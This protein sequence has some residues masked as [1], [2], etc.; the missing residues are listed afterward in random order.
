MAIELVVMEKEGMQDTIEI[1]G[2]VAH[3][4]RNVPQDKRG[5]VTLHGENIADHHGKIFYAY[6]AYHYANLTALPTIVHRGVGFSSI[7]DPLAP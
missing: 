4:G 3:F 2:V 5:I 1:D 6:N 7:L